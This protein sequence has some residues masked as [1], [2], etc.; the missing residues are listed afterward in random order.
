MTA[1]GIILFVVL[2]IA[3]AACKASS[4]SERTYEEHKEYQKRNDT[5]GGDK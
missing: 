1:I 5:K 4:E 2:A 3:W